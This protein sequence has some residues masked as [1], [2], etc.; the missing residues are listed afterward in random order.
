VALKKGQETVIRVKV[1]PRSSRS[2]LVGFEDGVWKLKLTSPPVDG[3]AN[4]GVK[5]FLAKSLGIAKGRLEIVSGEKSRLKSIR[6]EGLD[7]GLVQETLARHVS[8]TAKDM[9]I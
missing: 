7:Q 5:A 6:I 2:R 9:K 1:V 8:E 4:R 3:E